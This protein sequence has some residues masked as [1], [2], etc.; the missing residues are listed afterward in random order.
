MKHTI[1]LI[2]LLCLSFVGQAQ[3]IHCDS[4]DNNLRYVTIEPIKYTP[5]FQ[6]VSIDRLYFRVTNFEIKA[7][8]CD[9]T[10]TIH[11][12]LKFPDVV[13]RYQNAMSGDYTTPVQNDKVS[14][15]DAMLGIL[16]NI[17]DSATY[18]GFDISIEITAK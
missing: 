7:A 2:P 18:K 13:G 15:H 4:L 11:W 10:A 1:L 12:D 9:G 3:N 14:L 5:L 17:Q 8:E 16:Y 6:N